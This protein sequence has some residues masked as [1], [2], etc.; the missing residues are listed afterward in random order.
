MTYNNAASNKPIRR[1]KQPVD[2]YLHYTQSIQEGKEKKKGRQL[3][4]YTSASV[5]PS[6]VEF[7]VLYIMLTSAH[8]L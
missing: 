3:R 4:Q 2:K 7:H 1:N 6:L 5:E 8:I